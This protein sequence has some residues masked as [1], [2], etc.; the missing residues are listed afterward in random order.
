[1]FRQP[2]VKCVAGRWRAAV[3]ALSEQ[4]HLPG[5]NVELDAIDIDASASDRARESH[6]FC[7]PEC[8]APIC[9]GAEV[10]DGTEPCQTETR[11]NAETPTWSCA[12]GSSATHI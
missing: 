7:L 5:S 6:H 11:R 9:H 2:F 1:M 8:A 4:H 12:R 10:I 3:L